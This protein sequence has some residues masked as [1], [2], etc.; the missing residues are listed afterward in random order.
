MRIDAAAT[1]L[2]FGRLCHLLVRIAGPVRK[3]PIRRSRITEPLRLEEK[4]HFLTN[5]L[6]TK[7]SNKDCRSSPPAS[8]SSGNGLM[9]ECQD[10]S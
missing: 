6:S 1:Q 10:P 9:P 5:S 2:E 8:G 3:G 7:K 4:D